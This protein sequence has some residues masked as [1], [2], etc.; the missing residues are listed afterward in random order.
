MALENMNVIIAYTLC[1]DNPW[2]S[3][4]MALEKPGKLGKFFQL[5]DPCTSYGQWQCR[6]AGKV[7]VDLASHWLCHRL[8]VVIS[9]RLDGL[10]KRHEQPTGALEGEWHPLAF[11]A[12]GTHHHRSIVLVFCQCF[13]PALMH[14]PVFLF[15]SGICV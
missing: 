5:C 13:I 11:T 1:C 8:S 12:Q 3:I 9:C 10:K 15:I 14:S 2:K 7:T 6:A 4:I